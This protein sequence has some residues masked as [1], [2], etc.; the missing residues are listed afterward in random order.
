MILTVNRIYDMEK[1]VKVLSHVENIG[2]KVLYTNNIWCGF[3][4]S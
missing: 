3:C 1:N 4:Y 2:A